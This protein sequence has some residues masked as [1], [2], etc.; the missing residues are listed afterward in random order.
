MFPGFV[1]SFLTF[2]AIMI[3][4]DFFAVYFVQVFQT[5]PAELGVYTALISIP[6]ILSGLSVGRFVAW[7]G[8]RSTGLV[9][10][11]LLFGGTIMFLVSDS[12][13]GLFFRLSSFASA[14]S[15]VRRRLPSLF[16]TLRKMESRGRQWV[17]IAQLRLLQED[18]LLSPEVCWQD[19]RRLI[20]L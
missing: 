5:P 20:L 6:L 15:L 17:S 3:F 2:W 12:I 10:A 11:V 18:C 16:P 7:F 13:G 19:M 4:F 8:V 9:S 14:S 1:L